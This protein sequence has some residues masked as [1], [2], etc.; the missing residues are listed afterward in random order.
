MLVGENRSNCICELAN[1]KEGEGEGDR[2]DPHLMTL[3]LKA[4]VFL[5]FRTSLTDC[6]MYHGHLFYQVLWVAVKK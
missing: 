4:M 1:L 2:G 5:N 6:F 3:S